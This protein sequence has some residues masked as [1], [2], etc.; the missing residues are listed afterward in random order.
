MKI[1]RVPFL[2]ASFSLLV[3]ICQIIDKGVIAFEEWKYGLVFSGLWALVLFLCADGFLLS[4]CHDP[5]IPCGT[6]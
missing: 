4:D 1:N 3:Y 6:S 2:L 5:R